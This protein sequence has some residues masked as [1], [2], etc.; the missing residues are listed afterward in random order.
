M[1]GPVAV[2]A[3][4]AMVAASGC[5]GTSEEDEARDVVKQYADAIADG[6]ERK[7]CATLSKDSKKRFDR[8]K[9][10]CEQ[11]YEDFGKFL[12]GK[13]RGKLKGL[14]PQMEVDGDKATTKIDQPP[15]QGELRLNK[16][17][18]EWKIS[19]Q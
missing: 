4:V 1:R 15:L 11:A 5:G 13:Q 10:T 9:T 14:D 17:K 19:T 8:T 18:G 2:L 7:V 3:G 6:D 16:E 12:T